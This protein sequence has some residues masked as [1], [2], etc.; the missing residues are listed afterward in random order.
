[1][2]TDGGMSIQLAYI[3]LKTMKTQ[4]ECTISMR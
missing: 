1:M 2:T 3:R 4:Y